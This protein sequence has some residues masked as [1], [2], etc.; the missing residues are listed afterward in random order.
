MEE[1]LQRMIAPNADLRCTA[2][3]AMADSYWQVPRKVSSL[4]TSSLHSAFSFLRFH[5]L[6]VSVGCAFNDLS[7][8]I[9]FAMENRTRLEPQLI[10]RLRE[11]YGQVTQ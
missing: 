9:W 7:L 4:A 10:R 8:F 11:R 5:F 2:M 3:Q 1:L 6:N